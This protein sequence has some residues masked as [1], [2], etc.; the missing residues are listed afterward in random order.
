M[1]ADNQLAIFKVG[2]KY[3]GVMVSMSDDCCYVR[4]RMATLKRKAVF[5][6]SSERAAIARAQKQ[7]DLD[8]YE[9]GFRLCI[10]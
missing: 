5:I 8:Y 10:E 1:S 6:A 7:M 4:P 3:Y 2:R 9:Y